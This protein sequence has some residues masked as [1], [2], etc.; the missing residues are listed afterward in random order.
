[1]NSAETAPGIYDMNTP[2][3]CMAAITDMRH[4]CR[5]LVGMLQPHWDKIGST[6]RQ[7][8][9]LRRL[10]DAMSNRRADVLQERVDDYQAALKPYREQLVD[11]GSRLFWCADYIDKALPQEVVLDLLNV[12][13]VDRGQ[14]KPGDG[15]VMV[16]FGHGLENSVE[17]R[18]KDFLDTPLFKACQ[19]HFARELATNRKLKEATDTMMFGAGGIFEFL[20]TYTQQAD[21]S[22]T[23]NPPRLRIA[24]PLLDHQEKGDSNG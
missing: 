19:S 8:R 16:V 14:L 6:S 17:G 2:R 22:M 10:G 20:P 1:M 11:L 13:L 21:G 4:A 12:N 9:I 3:G 7:I 5:R 18:G 24:D 15:I 23:R